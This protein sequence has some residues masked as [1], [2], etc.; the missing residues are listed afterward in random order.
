MTEINE[1]PAERARK[2]ISSFEKAF[3]A[4]IILNEKHRIAEAAITKVTDAIRRYLEDARYYLET[5]K[6]TTSLASIA[7]AEGLLDALIFLGLA[8]PDQASPSSQ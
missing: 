7:Y 6:P 5:N 2:Y 4:S 8:K 1:D 3:R